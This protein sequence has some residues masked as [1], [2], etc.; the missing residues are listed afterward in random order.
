M[1]KFYQG[2]AINKYYIE[3]LDLLEGK[4]NLANDNLSR[5]FTS[6]NSGE[7]YKNTG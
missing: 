6:T 1:V 7:P 4:Y 2:K 5:G 3:G